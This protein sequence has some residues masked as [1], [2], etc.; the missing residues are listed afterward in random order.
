VLDTQGSVAGVE[1]S[2]TLRQFMR[3]RLALSEEPDP[4][5]LATEIADEL[6]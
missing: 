6:A 4:H 5:A 2:L 3:E 1:P